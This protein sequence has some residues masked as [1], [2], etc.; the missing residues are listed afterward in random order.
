MKRQF[1]NIPLPFEVGKTYKTTTGNASFK[2][3]KIVMCAREELG[4]N[5][6]MGVHEGEDYVSMLH[7]KGLVPETNRVLDLPEKSDWFICYVD[8]VRLPLRFNQPNSFWCALDGA[9]FKPEQVVWVD[10]K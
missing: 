3:T 9:T 2:I 6:F 10:D 1:K 7:G 5:F 4:I 8:G